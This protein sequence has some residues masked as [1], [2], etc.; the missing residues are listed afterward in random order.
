MSKKFDPNS[1]Y[2]L[3]KAACKNEAATL[4]SVGKHVSRTCGECSNCIKLDHTIARERGLEVSADYYCEAKSTLDL[5]GWDD[6]YYEI[7]PDDDYDGEDHGDWNCRTKEAEPCADFDL[8]IGIPEEQFY[9]DMI[10]WLNNQLDIEYTITS[11]GEYKSGTVCTGTG[12]PHIEVDTGAGC[13]KGYW[14]NETATAHVDS[15]AINRL[16]EALEELY[17]CTK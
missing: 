13:V 14:G 17:D 1:T 2:E 11:R 3:L 10:D 9:E 8:K 15:D 6:D 4:E 5:E 16:D 7:S 12:G